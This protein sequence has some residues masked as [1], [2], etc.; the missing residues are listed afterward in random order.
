M[1][2]VKTTGTALLIAALTACA[3]FMFGCADDSASHS[4]SN[5]STHRLAVVGK[6]ADATKGIVLFN[7]LGKDIDMV[8]INVAGSKDEPT[9]LANGNTWHKSENALIFIPGANEAA[10][11]DLVLTVGKK[12]YV[13]HDLDFTKITT[14]EVRLEGK[15]AYLSYVTD[16]TEMTTL[17]HENDLISRAAAVKKAKEDAAKK[18]AEEEAAQKAAEEEAARAAAEAE[19]AAQQQY[20]EPYVEQ[21]YVE[22]YVEQPYVEEPYVEQPYTEEYVEPAPTE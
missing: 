7:K 12:S 13:L 6:Q 9:V 2:L 5:S 14:G 16:G 3:L 15:I 20:V 10:A 4:S 21:P 11:S 17:E 18:K 19:A 1:K 8:S 22:P